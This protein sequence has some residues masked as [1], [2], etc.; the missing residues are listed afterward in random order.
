[1]NCYGVYQ[2]PKRFRKHFLFKQQHRPQDIDENG[3]K[4]DKRSFDKV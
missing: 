3:Q 4:D 2:I 1:M